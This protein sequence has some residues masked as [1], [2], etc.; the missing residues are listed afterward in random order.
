MCWRPRE[1][2]IYDNSLLLVKNKKKYSDTENS[3]NGA[4][5]F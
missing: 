3:Y 4:P 2:R 5:Y 1:N